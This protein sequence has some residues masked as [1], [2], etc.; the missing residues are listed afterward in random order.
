MVKLIKV[1]EATIKASETAGFKDR[2]GAQLFQAVGQTEEKKVAAQ[3]MAANHFLSID[4][5]P[6]WV[7]Y[8]PPA[9]S[10]E[11]IDKDMCAPCDEVIKYTSAYI[12]PDGSEVKEE[13]LETR[14]DWY[15]ASRKMIPLVCFNAEKRK[16]LEADI[17]TLTVEQKAKRTAI[18]RQIP[19]YAKNVANKMRDILDPD[20][21]NKGPSGTRPASIRFVERNEQ[22]RKQIDDLDTEDPYTIR[23]DVGKVLKLNAELKACY[24]AAVE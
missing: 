13:I 17:S 9:Q 19:Q 2:A 22:E 4:M 8:A 7:H 14:G 24:M 23:L 12:A 3:T 15:K 11:R 10:A 21:H 5:D 1:T 20:R 18:Q 6:D 16:L